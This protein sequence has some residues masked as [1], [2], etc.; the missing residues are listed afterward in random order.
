MDEP[1]PGQQPPPT[2]VVGVIREIKNYGVDQPVLPEIFVPFAQRPGGGGNVVV[3]SAMD[4][5]A[6]LGAMRSAAQT[7]DPDLPI[8]NLRTLESFVAENT[9]P[10]RLSVLLL[11]LF[12]GLALLLAAIGIYGVMSYGVT[13]RRREIGI[14]IALGAEMRDV[15]HLVVR[16][17]ALLAVLGLGTGLIGALAATRLI[18]RSLFGVRPND[19]ITFLVVASV[20]IVVAVIASYIPARR[21]AKIDPIVALRYE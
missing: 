5:G 13:Q 19:P 6:V 12:A 3:N 4:A 20:L 16:Q 21:A 18:A 15:I 8:Y 11:S 2:I 7:L 1:K 14:R 9:A 17:G 10:R